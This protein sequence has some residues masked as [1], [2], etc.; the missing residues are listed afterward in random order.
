[1]DKLK[2][3]LVYKFWILLGFA[4]I[5]PLV[6]W[7]IGSDEVATVIA[8]RKSTIEGKFKSIPQKDFVNN[9]WI[10][11]VEDINSNQEKGIDEAWQELA[12]QQQELRTWPPLLADK[13]AELGPD[14]PI[15]PG[16][17]TLY[18]R[19]YL[20]EWDNLY[21]IVDPRFSYP[22]FNEEKQMD[23]I[24]DVGVVSFDETQLPPSW[25]AWGDL[26]PTDKDMR[27]AQE[28]I[29]LYRS[30][31]EAIRNV[32]QGAAN[33]NDAAVVQI[34][35]IFLP[36]NLAPKTGGSGGKGSGG[37]GS[38]TDSHDDVEGGG[39]G[40]SGPGGSQALGFGSGSGYEDYF[41]VVGSPTPGGGPAGGAVG[42]DS[43]DDEGGARGGGSSGGSKEDRI[44][45][46][47]TDQFKTRA[48]NLELL[49]DQRRLPDVLGWLSNSPW[50]VKI[51]R[52]QQYSLDQ[53][54]GSAPSGGARRG[55]SG[56]GRSGPG[57]G[58]SGGRLN[59]GGARASAAP[60]ARTSGGS[61]SVNNPYLVH[62]GI[63]GTMRIYKL[64]AAVAGEAAPDDGSLQT[65]NPESP[66]SRPSPRLE[67][68]AKFPLFKDLYGAGASS[69]GRSR[70]GGGRR[71][72]G[73]GGD[74]H[75]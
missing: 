49:I 35:E 51:L 23:E 40:R 67:I 16:E 1:M 48:F 14:T 18:P 59:L 12:A 33:V 6:G 47:E 73:G 4:L 45:V 28:D 38:R 54:G 71:G 41:D 50:P 36:I 37:S 5:V 52:V 13:I 62:V 34:D 63:T 61:S 72:G 25:R 75:D 31:L 68:A 70:R 57:F 17:R 60:R 65:N 42:G 27:A 43:H 7:W 15:P 11:G 32:N 26:Q 3:I 29:W 10:K 69:S 2:E 19:E 21:Y 20:E 66:D 24:H 22:E 74:D 8:G 56:G 44:Y 53:T 39:G 58:M 55:S 64:R 30:L 46:E 9:T